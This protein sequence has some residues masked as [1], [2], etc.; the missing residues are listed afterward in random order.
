MYVGV[1]PGKFDAM[2]QDKRMPSARR[3]DARR[4]WDV[5]ALDV[6]FDALPCEDTTQGTSWDD[7]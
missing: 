3:I 4:V 1:S 6:A 7:V 2:V 5:R